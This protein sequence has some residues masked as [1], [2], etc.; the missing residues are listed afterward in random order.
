MLPPTSTSAAS[1]GAALREMRQEAGIKIREM[2]RAVGISATTLSL[3]ERG[4]RP[5]SA[6]TVA[7][8]ARAI[9]DEI[10]HRRGDAA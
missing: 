8:Y 4:R 2:A 6:E 10:A 1:V 3:Y 9:A 7:R 5:V